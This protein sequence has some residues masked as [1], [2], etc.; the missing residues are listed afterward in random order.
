MDDLQDWRTEFYRGMDVHVTALPHGDSAL[1]DYT[2]RI[3]QPGEDPG[4]SNELVAQ[5]G[6]DADYPSREAAVEAGF[7][8]GYAMVDQMLAAGG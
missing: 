5:S 2:V 3:T 1:W 6:D 7:R 8:K 4:S